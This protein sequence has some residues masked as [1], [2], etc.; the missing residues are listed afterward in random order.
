MPNYFTK[1]L[2]FTLFLTF[3]ISCNTVKYVHEN[4]NLLKKNTISVDE[5]KKI[6]SELNSYLVQRPNQ[7]TLGLPL[8]LGFYNIGNL[9]FEKTFDEWKENHPG[10]TKSYDKIFSKKQTKV[11]YNTHKGLNNWFLTKG[12]APVIYDGEKTKKSAKSLKDY[13][14]SKGFFEA[15]VTYDFHQIK[16]K[17]V[18]VDYKITT[19]NQYYFDSLS[20]EIES[21]ILDSIYKANSEYSIIKSKNPFVFNDFINEESRLISLFRNSGIYHFTDNSMGF[22]T[23]SIKED[24]YKNIL[25]KIPNRIISVNDSL[26]KVPYKILKVN[27]INVYTDFSLKNKGEKFKD[28][29]NYKGYNFYSYGKMKFNPKYLM[30][31]LFITPNGVYKDSERNLTRRHLRNL[32][33]FSSSIDL[34]YTEKGDSLRADIYLKPLKKFGLTFDADMTTS[35]L[36]PFGVLGKSTFL[37]RNIFKGSEIVELSFQGSFFNVANDP[38]NSSDF[39]NAWEFISSASVKIPR[40]LFPLNTSSIIPK[41]MIPRTNFDA[42]VSFQQNIGLDR[43]TISTGMAYTWKSSKKNGH[44]FDLLNW[45][46][47]KNQNIDNYFFIYDS[48]YQKLNLVSESIFNSPL[49]QQNDIILGFMDDVLDPDNDYDTTDPNAY[50]VTSDVDERRDILIEDVMVPVI[51]YSYVYNSRENI[52]DNNF[53]Y[54]TARLVS[55]GGIVTSLS[56][57]TNEIGQKLLF[58]LP[59]AQYFKIELEYKKYWELKKNNILVFRTFVG[60]A[61]PYGNSENI[62]FSRSYSAG[63]SNEI[64]AWRTFDLGLGAQKSIL[65]YNVGTFKLVSNLEYRFKITDKIYSALFIDAGNIWD[66]TDSNLY[67]DEAKLINFSSFKNTAVGSGFG[68]RYDFG[69]LVFRFDIGFKTYEPY[70]NSE[71]KWF[72]N[73]NFGNAVYNIG[74]NYPF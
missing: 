57:K 56:N 24:Y 49:P 31:S 52:N 54:F 15:D 50:N 59:I 63:G 55:A 16:E 42:S 25:L 12:Q 1:L 29:I 72:I 6:E 40:I 70:L 35:N 27:E 2:F 67:G 46:Y 44:R 23:D 71:D 32:K 28:S 8:S 41:Y 66:I 20:T 68:I 5:K 34:K 9:D 47:I 7:S 45:Q 64:R 37:G 21:P 33:T 19:N 60:A 22:W 43:Q 48:E 18:G 10:K 14:I 53:S 58:D 3:F 69:F 26:Y 73:Y 39:F 36:K 4:E 61:K 62:P 30:N 17:Q 65:E 38:S 74:I 11:I 51:S 13:Y